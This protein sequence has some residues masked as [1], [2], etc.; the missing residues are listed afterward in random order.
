MKEFGVERKRQITTVIVGAL[1][2]IVMGSVLIVGFQLA[3]QVTANVTALQTASGLQ[4]Y[5]TLLSQHLNSLRDRLE[6]RAYAGQALADRCRKALDADGVDRLWASEV[7][8]EAA[9]LLRLGNREDGAGYPFRVGRRRMD[10]EVGNRRSTGTEQAQV[11]QSIFRNQAIP[12][13]H[14][15]EG[16]SAA[17]QCRV[18]RQ[19]MR[20]GTARRHRAFEREAP[21]CAIL[22]LAGRFEH[23]RGE[24]D[25]RPQP[26]RHAVPSGFD[27][28]N[29]CSASETSASDIA[30]PTNE[31][32]R[33]NPSSDPRS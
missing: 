25:E 2:A 21:V 16:L 18:H 7:G 19:L 6:A 28:T 9:R 30:S 22:C 26:A 5:P 14:D 33:Y 12:V 27:R 1:L 29:F 10:Q 8:L 17:E 15:P 13:R 20:A 31:A 4:T 3:T 32:T 24:D 11:R 23:Q